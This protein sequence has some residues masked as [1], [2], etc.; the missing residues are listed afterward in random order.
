[1]LLQFYFI[2]NRDKNVDRGTTQWHNILV[3]II[4]T[5]NKYFFKKNRLMIRNICI[6]K[7]YICYISN[8]HIPRQEIWL[9]LFVKIANMIL[10]TYTIILS[11]L[12]EAN[13]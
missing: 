2:I 5:Y 9:N 8:K 1:M 7:K 11:C 13:Q 6:A 12:S 4:Y 10:S 3:C